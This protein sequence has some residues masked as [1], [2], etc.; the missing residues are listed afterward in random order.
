M[1]EVL[2]VLALIPLALVGAVI[3]GAVVWTLLP[4][5]VVVLGAV[6][7]LV[8]SDS[9]AWSSHAIYPGVVAFL[10]LAWAVSRWQD[11]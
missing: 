8:M 5:A 1:L 4:Y 6:V 9:P 3:A 2:L 7:A 10:G 11:R